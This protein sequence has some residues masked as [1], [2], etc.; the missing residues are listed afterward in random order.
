MVYSPELTSKLN[1]NLHK[2]GLHKEVYFYC[3]YVDFC[4]LFLSKKGSSRDIAKCF[5]ALH[6]ICTL[7]YFKI[8]I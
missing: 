3:K 5:L 8:Y 7:I 6:L 4:S 1:L 2:R